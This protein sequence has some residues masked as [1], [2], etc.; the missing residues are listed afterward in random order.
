[1]TIGG[2]TI[3]VAVLIVSSLGVAAVLTVRDEN[4]G[5]SD[6]RPQSSEVASDASLAFL[7]EYRHPKNDG[8][9]AIGSIVVP[10]ATADRLV[11]EARDKGLAAS[12]PLPE[13][14]PSGY[15]V[16]VD[17]D[18]TGDGLVPPSCFQETP[19]L[20]LEGWLRQAG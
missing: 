19:I 6:C 9:A 2:V 11:T 5:R 16:V 17:Y 7:D 10:S 18:P 12:D 14:G 8:Y 13:D 20:Y 4:D 1:M 3:G 15:V